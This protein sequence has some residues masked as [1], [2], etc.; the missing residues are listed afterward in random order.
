MVSAQYCRAWWEVGSQA[1]ERGRGCSSWYL[2]WCCSYW[3]CLGAAGAECG[4]STTQINKWLAWLLLL[5]GS[6]IQCPAQ[7]RNGRAK[8]PPPVFFC[9][10]VPTPQVTTGR[11]QNHDVSPAGPGEWELGAGS[12]ELG[13]GR[14]RPSA[15]QRLIISEACWSA[16]FASL[17]P[18]TGFTLSHPHALGRWVLPVLAI[19]TGYSHPGLAWPVARGKLPLE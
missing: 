12:W 1:A 18:L 8:W 3:C 6:P 16:V 11:G 17:F 2:C 19:R 13:A 7:H 9:P 15:T 14:L 5:A 10:A 4:A